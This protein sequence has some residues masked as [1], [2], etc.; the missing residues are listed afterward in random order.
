MAGVCIGRGSVAISVLL[1][2]IMGQTENF[3]F[4]V[5]FDRRLLAI[6]DGAYSLSKVG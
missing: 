6:D 1:V 4:E 2:D 5:L 3:L